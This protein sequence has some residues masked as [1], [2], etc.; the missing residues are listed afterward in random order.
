MFFISS[1][2]RD[3][4]CTLLGFSRHARDQAA[5]LVAGV[6]FAVLRF[7]VSNYHGPWLVD[8]IASLVSMGSLTLFLEVWKPKKIWTSAALVNRHDT[9]MEDLPPGALAST[10]TTG[11]ASTSLVRAWAP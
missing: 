5:A 7:L 8:V 2:F 6:A 4:R 3:Y 1:N 10:D 11:T 9:S